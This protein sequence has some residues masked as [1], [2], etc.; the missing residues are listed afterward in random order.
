VGVRLSSGRRVSTRGLRGLRPTSGKVRE[1]VMNILAPWLE[2]AVFVDLYAGTGAVGMEAM[3]RGA[4]AVY[5]V[6]ADRRKARRLR[7]LLSGCGCGF[8]AHILSM[9]AQSFLRQARKQGLGAQVV[10]ADPPYFSGQLGQLL[11]LLCQE[12][13]LAPEAVVLLEHHA[14]ELPPEEVPPLRKERTYRYGDTVL[15]LYRKRP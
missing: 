2:A 4:K 12:G 9:K 1:A 15:S 5:F 8:K 10:F 14:K 6:E 3:S 7:E 13:V 11:E